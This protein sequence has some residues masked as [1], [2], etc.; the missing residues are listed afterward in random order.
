MFAAAQTYHCPLI[1]CPGLVTV[2]PSENPCD[3]IKKTK[4]KNILTCKLFSNVSIGVIKEVTNEDYSPNHSESVV[5][6]PLVKNK[7]Q[8]D[9]CTF[10]LIT[11][12]RSL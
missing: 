12:S 6:K 7:L 8:D 5:E 10:S 3:I 9:T 11:S 2:F 1:Y 4:A